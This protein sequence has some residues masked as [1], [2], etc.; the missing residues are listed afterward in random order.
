[1]H[2]LTYLHTYYLVCVKAGAQRGTVDDVQKLF[3]KL[4]GR[5]V[6]MDAG[7]FA[8]ALKE[9]LGTGT[10]IIIVAA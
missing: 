5:D 9:I 7:E 3:D 4:S 8:D 2:F 6:Q 1:M 10:S